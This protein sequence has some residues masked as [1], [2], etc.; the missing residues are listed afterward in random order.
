MVR[1]WA[2]AQLWPRGPSGASS[3][4][5]A[6]IIRAAADRDREAVLRKSIEMKFLTGYEV[7]VGGVAGLHGVGGW[8]W[9]GPACETLG[10]TSVYTGWEHRLPPRSPQ[11]LGLLE[12]SLEAS[13]T[14]RVQ[15]RQ[16]GWA[17]GECGVKVAFLLLWPE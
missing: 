9:A 13:G 12:H 15:G 4:P 8:T 16:V 3:C 5:F 1:G 6:Q 11:A 14:L 2:G 7:K 17:P 10:R